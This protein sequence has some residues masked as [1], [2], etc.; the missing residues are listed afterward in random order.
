MTMG[1]LGNQKSVYIRS[2]L[3]TLSVAF[4]SHSV[5]ANEEV[6]DYEKYHTPLR[7]E[8][9]ISGS[10]FTVDP[11]VW[12]YTSEFARRWGMPKKW[13]D[14]SIQGAEAIAY[15]VVN[16]NH[17]TCGYF[18]DANACIP[19]QTCLFDFYI[20]KAA[21]LPWKDNRPQGYAIG[22]TGK[23]I[24]FLTQQKGYDGLSYYKN[25]KS[26]WNFYTNTVAFD[27][28]YYAISLN[29]KKLEARSYGIASIR[30]YDR[31][32]FSD[33]DYISVEGSCL[34]SEKAY[35]GASEF[36]ISE[37]SV[38]DGTPTKYFGKINTTIPI[39][40]RAILTK[41]F[42]K[43]VSDYH[44]KHYGDHLWKATQIELGLN[45]E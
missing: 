8:Y 35:L 2:G 22:L 42:T 31:E 44:S 6:S 34:F 18:R 19:N 12:V 21:N 29:P 1:K 23:S 26:E 36:V 4:S 38:I 40:H 15:K 9:K 17:I 33:L 16:E 11:H 24:R 30:E 32:L 45:R 43:R 5:I 39:R 7:I 41:S 3:L 20:S 28:K 10:T 27:N 25:G 14:D 13:I 37:P